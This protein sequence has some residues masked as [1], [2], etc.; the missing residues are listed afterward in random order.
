PRWALH[1]FPTRRSSDLT[2]DRCA[3]ARAAIAARRTA[4][5]LEEGLEDLLVMDRGDAD[6]GIGH[7]EADPVRGVAAPDQPYLQGHRSFFGR[8]EEHTS[9]LQSRENLV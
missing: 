9:E 1:S 8:S 5:D 3:Q 6:A 2:G 4:L 7:G